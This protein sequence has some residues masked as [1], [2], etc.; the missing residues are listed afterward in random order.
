MTSPYIR[1][2]WGSARICEQFVLNY[3]TINTKV[4][5]IY[6]DLGQAYPLET[7]GDPGHF[8]LNS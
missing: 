4:L 2:S 6:R 7:P 5:M 1:N 3:D 8:V